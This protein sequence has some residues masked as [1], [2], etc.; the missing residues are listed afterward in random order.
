VHLGRADDLAGIEDVVR[1]EALLD[2]PEIGDDARAEHRLMEFGT[3]QAIAMLAGVRALVLAYHIERFLGYGAHRLDVLLELLVED[4]THMKAAFGRVRI[5][6]AA[7][8]VPGEDGVEA[9][10]II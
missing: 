9:L 6:G 10:G 2:F 1:V 5:H 7:S 4:R 8:A 3:H